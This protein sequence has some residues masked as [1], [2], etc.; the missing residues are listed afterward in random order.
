MITVIALAFILG[1]FTYGATGMH[2]RDCRRQ[3]W[4]ITKWIVTGRGLERQ[5]A[6]TDEYCRSC[7]EKLCASQYTYDLG[8]G[9]RACDCCWPKIQADLEKMLP[10]WFEK[11]MP[12]E[13]KPQAAAQIV[14]KLEGAGGGG[15]SGNVGV[16]W[17]PGDPA[18]SPRE[19]TPWCRQTNH[20]HYY[21]CGGLVDFGQRTG[22]DV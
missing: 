1:A 10:E 2:D 11:P 22:R 16:I 4:Q 19:C 8:Q 15:G 12:E 9:G 21:S 6:L 3:Y 13:K 5:K 14:Q 7:E 17:I 20:P 18:P